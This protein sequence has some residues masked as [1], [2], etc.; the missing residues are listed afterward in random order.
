MHLIGV[1]GSKYKISSQRSGRLRIRA[2]LKELC[3]HVAPEIG[4]NSVLGGF[5]CLEMYIESSY[6]TEVCYLGTEKISKHIS[7]QVFKKLY[8]QAHFQYLV[9]KS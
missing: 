1:R 3:L 8:I 2:V 6:Y 4:P 5:K 7:I 9:K